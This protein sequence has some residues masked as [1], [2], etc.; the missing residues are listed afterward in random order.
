MVVVA[1]TDWIALVGF[2]MLDELVA[3]A[4]YNVNNVNHYKVCCTNSL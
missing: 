3:M 4:T 1:G 2:V